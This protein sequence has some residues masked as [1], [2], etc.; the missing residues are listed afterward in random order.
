MGDNLTLNF[1]NES[2]SK[3]EN[4]MKKERERRKILR[5]Y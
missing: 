3:W 5:E 2:R 1:E 4:E